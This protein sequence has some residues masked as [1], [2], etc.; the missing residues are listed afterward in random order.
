MFKHNNN[1]IDDIDY[2]HFNIKYRYICELVLLL[3]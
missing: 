1:T 2:H 3:I